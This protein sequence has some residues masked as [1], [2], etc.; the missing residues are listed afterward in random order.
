VLS[1]SQ[2]TWY[3]VKKFFL[4]KKSSSCNDKNWISLSMQP[5]SPLAPSQ[6]LRN[7]GTSVAISLS[8]FL[9]AALL[10]HYTGC[11]CMTWRTSDLC[12]S[13]LDCNDHDS[14]VSLNELGMLIDLKN[15]NSTVHII[16]CSESNMGLGSRFRMRFRTSIFVV[17]FVRNHTYIIQADPNS[18]VSYCLFRKFMYTKQDEVK[19]NKFN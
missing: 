15:I 11:Y 19:L 6:L 5:A 2:D 13:V 10:L 8:L 17:V 16:K 9:R 7:V 4:S 14:S 3:N 1:E 18:R 12:L